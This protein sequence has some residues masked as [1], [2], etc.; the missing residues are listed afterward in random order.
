MPVKW[1]E[2]RGP[3][4]S[5]L[6][7]AYEVVDPS[8]KLTPVKFVIALVEEL[9]R[10]GVPVWQAFEVAGNSL[11][12]T[13]L[14]QKYKGNNLGGWKITK[15]GAEAFERKHGRKP[16]WY[17]A[18]GNRAAGATLDDLK[19]GDPP[20]CWYW[21][22]DSA[23]DYLAQWMARFVPRPRRSDTREALE[24]DRE[25]TANYRLAGFLFWHRDPTW[26]VAL[27]DAGYKGQNTDANPQ[28]SYEGHLGLVAWAKA[29]YAQAKLGV[30]IDGDW[31]PKS[32]AAC[33]EFQRRRG[34][35]ATGE[36]DDATLAALATAKVADAP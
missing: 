17:R 15:S 9:Q 6:D 28:P 1:N 13:A 30:K 24:P 12:E 4:P 20:W 5:W 26:F 25:Q 23:A 27:C 3:Q 31:G 18:P 22:F 21:V 7:L 16:R 14:G 2:P 32:R 11:N 29:F 36:L 8:P 35:P 10:Q 33:A 34:L 19:G